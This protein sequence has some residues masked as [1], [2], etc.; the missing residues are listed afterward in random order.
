MSLQSLMEDAVDGDALKRPFSLPLELTVTDDDVVA[1]LWAH[2]EGPPRDEFALRA[3]RIGV[4]ALKQAQGQIDATSVRQEG[5]RLLQNVER[6]L[7][8]HQQLLNERLT[9]QL[10]TYFDP[11][12]GRFHERIER[13]IRQDG[14][15]EQL[16][17]RNVGDED[18]RL[19]QTL[20]LHV[21]D[22]SPL[23]R[24]IDPEAGDGLTA[25]LRQCLEEK[26]HD[27]RQRVL[28]QFSLDNKEGAL[29]RFLKEVQQH[30][31]GI[32]GDLTGKIDKAV[33]EFSLDDENSAL[34]RLVGRVTDAQQTITREFSLDAKESALS[35]LRG[36]I[37]DLLKGQ[38]ESNSK[39]QEE[40]KVAIGELQAR[41]AEAARSTRHGIEFEECLFSVVQAEAQRCG[42]VAEFTKEKAG[43]ISRCKI[44]DIVVSL[45]PDCAAPDARIVFEAKEDQSYHDRHAL[46]ELDTGRK[47][48]DAQIG[49]FVYSS[50]T[51]P[52]GIEP[53][54]RLGNSILIVWNNEDAASDLYVKV[55]FTLAKALCVGEQRKHAEEAA[56]LAEMERGVQA[57]ENRVKD[58]DQIQKSA[59]TIRNSADTILENERR[60]RKT[61]DEQ[62]ENLQERIGALKSLVG[63][64]STGSESI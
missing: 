58:L 49:V 28:E 36:E 55:A 22:D 60:F 1:A 41:K 30:Y 9:T 20:A 10:K 39:F 37:V 61:I 31:D 16:L 29:C 25:A 19:C 44:G 52:A 64:A 4:L 50:K 57:I 54:R 14:E 63:T 6:A 21:G 51:A 17:R 5:E 48:R 45:G 62:L 47:N 3:L 27:Q 23:M 2:P 13:L 24:V 42:D 56:D 35:R 7:Q 59:T 11:N 33:G 32:S 15:L 8:Q 43:H 40:V 53:F 26:L 34:S 12:D 38:S 46:D 18:S